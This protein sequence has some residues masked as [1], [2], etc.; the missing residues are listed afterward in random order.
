MEVHRTASRLAETAVAWR[1]DVV[2]LSSPALAGAACFPM[3]V[4]GVAH[5]CLATWWMVMRKGSPPPDFAWRIEAVARGYAACDALIAPSA[6]FAEAT[7]QIYGV[8]AIPVHNGR[9]RVVAESPV[10]DISIATAGRLWDEGKG[11]ATL[12]AAAA[13]LEVPVLALGPLIG[14]QGQQVTFNRLHSLGAKPAAD[15]A[16]TLARTRIFVS[17]ARY[18]PFGL[19]VLEAAQAGCALVLSDIAT[20]RELWDGAAIFVAPGD[21]AGLAEA[22]TRLLHGRGEVERLSAMA[23]LRAERYCLADCIAATRALHGACLQRAAEPVA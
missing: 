13:M 8:S 17:A 4:V 23:R 12:D 14:P 16:E 10:R 11:A 18:E 1:A 20:F 15:V 6:A 5:S 21:A 7:F 19:A 3:P 2:H 9:S 22:L